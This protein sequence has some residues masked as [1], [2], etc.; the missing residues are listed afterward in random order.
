MS[1]ANEAASPHASRAVE[2]HSP[3]SPKAT[4]AASGFP[5]SPRTSRAWD[6]KDISPRTTR[7]PE[8]PLDEESPASS[9]LWQIHPWFQAFQPLG[10]DADDA[11]FQQAVPHLAS[12]TAPMSLT[13]GTLGQLLSSLAT[14]K[15][16]GLVDIFLMVVT[17]LTFT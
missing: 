17:Y 3:D 5:N 4:L 10:F 11:L 8:H 2:S 16:S 6:Q 14:N 7:D 1:D 15:W 12:A 9:K 13:F